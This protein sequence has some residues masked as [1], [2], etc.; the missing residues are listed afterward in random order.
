MTFEF[1]SGYNLIPAGAIGG[2]LRRLGR[3]C[4]EQGLDGILLTHRTDICY[5]AG[6]SQQ[7]VVLVDADG[8]DYVFMRRSAERAAAESPLDVTPIRGLGEA[9][10]GITTA[11]GPQAR[12]GLTFDVMSAQA[13]QGWAGR[14]PG[15]ELV[16]ATAPLLDLK[17]V[18]DAWELEA[19]AA[20]GRLAGKVYTL[21][22][23]LLEPGVEELWLAGQLM[24]LAMAEGSIPLMEVRGESFAYSWHFIS[25]PEG[26]VPS[27]IDAPCGGYG[28]SPAFPQGPCDKRLRANE[29]IN[30]D[31]GI[32]LNGYMTDQTRTY[33][34][35]R[36]SEKVKAAHQCL[37]EVEAALLENLRPGAISGELYGLAMKI[38]AEHHMDGVFLGRPEQRIRFVGHGIGNELGAPPY[39][40]QGSDAVVR[41]GETYAL[42]LKIVLDEGPV[43]LENT[44]AVRPRGPAVLLSDIP[45]HLSVL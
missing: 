1:P 20:A 28:V 5:A 41:A 34:L 26:A 35:G 45:G 12:L 43:G 10:Q 9:A 8:R 15:M 17:A 6:T 44:V 22:A 25:G 21:A 24:A 39:L 7:G 14:L 19:M 42:E 27:V 38:A 32:S 16:D 18:K 36:A 4:A 11:I 13:H 3:L 31:F 37:E 40:L 29:P 30:V 23:A 33:V 2:R